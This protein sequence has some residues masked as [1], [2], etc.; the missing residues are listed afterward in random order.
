MNIKPKKSASWS[1]GLDRRRWTCLSWQC[2]C[3]SRARRS[4]SWPPAS[5]STSD[6]PSH[7][8]SQLCLSR[9]FPGCKD[10]RI[11]S[12]SK[13]SLFYI[14]LI[15]TIRNS[16]YHNMNWFDYSVKYFVCWIPL[17][18]LCFVVVH[19]NWKAHRQR[20]QVISQSIS[21]PAFYRHGTLP[22]AAFQMVTEVQRVADDPFSELISIQ[23]IFNN[24]N[25]SAEQGKTFSRNLL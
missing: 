8:D 3:R 2:R 24:W 11:Y 13:L 9:T 16:S 20:L 19:S 1:P 21:R 25:F 15:I 10:L 6:L 5:S 23:T 22:C 4:R 17:Q 18:Q 14:W 7:S 12:E